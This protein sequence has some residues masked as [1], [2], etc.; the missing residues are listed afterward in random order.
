MSKHG[1]FALGLVISVGLCSCGEAKTWKQEVKEA[2]TVETEQVVETEAPKPTDT[3]KPD[4]SS[5]H[6]ETYYAK[7]KVNVRKEASTKSKSVGKIQRG[8]AVEKIDEMDGWASV[9]YKEEICYVKAEYLVTEDELGNGYVIAIDAGHQKK[10]NNQLE[11][12]GPGASKKKAKVASGTKGCVSG[13]AEYELTLAVSKKLKKELESRGYEVIMTRESSDVN[14]SNAERA[15]IA[16]KAKADAFIRVHANGSDNSSVNGA[17]TIC[18]TASNPFNGKL[19]GE[20]KKLSR[21]VLDHLVSSTGCKR[22]R[23]WETDTMSGINWCQ[24][25]VTIVEMGYMTNANEDALMAKK[26]YQ[27]KIAKGIADGIDEYFK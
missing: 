3:P 15:E 23:I 26:E 14:I 25:P 20:S 2:S 22:E 8:D 12:I 21:C 9:I 6:T 10:G 7:T 24:V 4:L 1:M 13:L 27:N 5:L 19:A 11:P 18:Q 16:N 17:M